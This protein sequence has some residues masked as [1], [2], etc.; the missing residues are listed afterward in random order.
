MISMNIT[1]K[2]LIGIFGSTDDRER[3]VDIV[4]SVFMA[5]PP[6]SHHVTNKYGTLLAVARIQWSGA[7]LIALVEELSRRMPGVMF[8]LRLE[9][10][11]GTQIATRRLVIM[12]GLVVDDVGPVDPLPYVHD[13]SEVPYEDGKLIV[14]NPQRNIELV[15]HDD[16]SVDYVGT[17]IATMDR[18]YRF[19]HE[20]I[21]SRLHGKKRR[22][23]RMTI[24]VMTALD[25][26]LTAEESSRVDQH[27]ER[28]E[29]NVA[30]LIASLDGREGLRGAG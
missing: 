2:N 7:S 29:R 4:Q 10:L 17:F 19:V 3:I 15:L 11:P 28:H 27:W 18:L 1:S 23:W 20:N 6:Y 16:Y 9:V 14:L 21:E 22:D 12:D 8:D 26:L 13:S 5:S 24:E 25:S 30:E